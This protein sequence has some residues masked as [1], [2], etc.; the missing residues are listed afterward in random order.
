MRLKAM[1]K[2]N[3]A[4]DVTGKK[5]DGYHE[6]R[7]IMQTIGMYD[8]I[9][10]NRSKI[11]GIHMTTNLP[12]LPTDERNLAVKAIRLLMDEFQIEDG[13]DVELFK[14]IPIAA[15]MAGG[16]TDAAA[17]FIGMNHLFHLKLSKRELMKRAA[18]LGADIPYCILRGTALA[19]GIGEKLTALPEIPPC[20]IL[21]AKPGIVVSTKHVYSNLKLDEIHHH[22][23]VDGMIQS[24]R[25]ESLEGIVTRLENV[26]ETVTIPE[27]PVIDEIKQMMI[28][29]GALGSL[30]SGSGPTV[31]GIFRDRKQAEKA[32]ERLKKSE[33]AKRIVLT[34]PFNRKNRKR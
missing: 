28:E 2:I 3:L 17:A 14:M 13:V 7:M 6:V 20:Y 33:L 22:P 31:F 34:T 26:L 23:D 25:D 19:E 16:S 8:R 30:M 12:Y 10:M 4:L 15:G 18:K 5:P 29:E 9:E 11:P 32:M 21:I 27:Y 1:A 24:I